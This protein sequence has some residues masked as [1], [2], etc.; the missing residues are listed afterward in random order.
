MPEAMVSKASVWEKPAGPA[1]LLQ[2][3]RRGGFCWFDSNIKV[4]GR[5]FAPAQGGSAHGNTDPGHC[6]K[7]WKRGRSQALLVPA[8]KEPSA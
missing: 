7:C 1:G 5:L 3:E 4:Q 2:R 6:G 8:V